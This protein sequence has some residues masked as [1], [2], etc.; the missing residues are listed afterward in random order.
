MGRPERA[1]AEL[2]R[3]GGVVRFAVYPRRAAEARR[4]EGAV[5]DGDAGGGGPEVPIALRRQ[6]PLLHVLVVRTPHELGQARAAA[7]GLEVFAQGPDNVYEVRLHDA[8][9]RGEAERGRPHEAAR[10]R[11]PLLQEEVWQGGAQ[12]FA[13][14]EDDHEA[15][16]QEEAHQRVGDVDA[17][18]PL[19]LAEGAPQAGADQRQAEK[20]E[21]RVERLIGLAAGAG[22]Q[23][24]PQD[25]LAERRDDVVQVANQAQYQD[26]SH[27][28]PKGAAA[29]ELVHW[30]RHP[31]T[32]PAAS[33]A[34]PRCQRKGVATAPARAHGGRAPH[35]R[36]ALRL[37]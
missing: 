8:R 31:R 34:P 30:P 10:E 18:V 4:P 21:R 2:R 35:R 29:A 24:D 12:V 23:G 5:A 14:E 37:S 28:E 32:P 9:Q 20:A 1:S 7:A 36:G 16:V 17:Q 13:E 27:A 26:A 15:G 25:D 11:V 19:G 33:A 6:V 22:D 3:V